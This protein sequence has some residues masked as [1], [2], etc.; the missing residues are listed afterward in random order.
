MA[1]PS[2]TADPADDGSTTLASGGAVPVTV[3]LVSAD[4]GLWA[5]L[6]N[7]LPALPSPAA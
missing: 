6:T 1:R 3:H 4:D 2:P 5:D 7:R